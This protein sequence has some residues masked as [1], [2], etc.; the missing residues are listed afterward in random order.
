MP[1]VSKPSRCRALREVREPPAGWACPHSQPDINLVP[2]CTPPCATTHCHHAGGALVLPVPVHPCGGSEGAAPDLR[3]SRLSHQGQARILAHQGRTHAVRHADGHEQE[4]GVVGADV[5]LQRQAVAAG[6]AEDG[7]HDDL[8][9]DEQHVQQHSLC[10]VE[11]H[12]PREVGVV[13]NADVHRQEGNK[14]GKWNGVVQ[15]RQRP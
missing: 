7:P 9:D 10:G 15:C 2:G 4:D 5:R 8:G 3:L 14:R 13:D 6:V 1:P 11:A 12:K